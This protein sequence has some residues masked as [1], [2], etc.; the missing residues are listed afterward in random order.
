[1]TGFSDVD[2]I[3]CACFVNVTIIE[4]ELRVRLDTTLSARVFGRTRD[5]TPTTRLFVS[6]C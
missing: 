5:F 2:E 6:L 4:G 3:H 1:V